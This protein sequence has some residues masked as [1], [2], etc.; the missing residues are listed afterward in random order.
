[1]PK[2][3]DARLYQPVVIDSS[4]IASSATSLYRCRPNCG[5]RSRRQRH[6]RSRT[7]GR[8]N[9]T[10]TGRRAQY[11]AQLRSLTATRGQPFSLHVR[12]P[13]S[14]SLAVLVFQADHEFDSRHSLHLIAPSQ[15]TLAL[16]K[17]F[18]QPDDKHDQAGPGVCH[19]HRRAMYRSALSGGIFG[20]RS[21]SVDHA[22]FVPSIHELR[23][24]NRRSHAPRFRPERASCTADVEVRIWRASLDTTVLRRSLPRSCR[25]AAWGGC[26]R[27]ALCRQSRRRTSPRAPMSR[28]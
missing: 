25:V 14:Q 8:Q 4:S 15:G 21:C 20:H 28:H 22:R 16:L 23:L 27:R 24:R 1:M 3:S 5:T 26:R 2:R 17:L 12:K 13:P 18:E 9:R 6:K 7:I 11:P 19:D 10:T